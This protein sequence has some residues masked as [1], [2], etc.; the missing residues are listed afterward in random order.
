M[1]PNWENVPLPRDWERRKAERVRKNEA[2]FKAH[3]ERRQALERAAAGP[4]E[5]IP[6]VCECGDAGCWD[7]L[8]VTIP[9]IERAHSA[10][11]RYLVK[12]RH[13]MPDFERVVSQH[14][15]YWVVEKYAPEDVPAATDAS[16]TA[17]PASP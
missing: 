4:D 17:E 2:A 5:P 3:N 11:L 7:S 10:K 14:D 13:V 15:N 6:I 16:L 9:E 8:P 12:P 1:E